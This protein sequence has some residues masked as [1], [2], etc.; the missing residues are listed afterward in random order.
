MKLDQTSAQNGY[1]GSVNL[2]EP[3]N[4]LPNT[5]HGIRETKFK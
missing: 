3:F 5:T 1:E 4:K 2:Y